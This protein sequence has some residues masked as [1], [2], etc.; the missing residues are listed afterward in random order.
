MT[1]CHLH[2]SDHCLLHDAGARIVFGSRVFCHAAATI[3]NSL[4]AALTDNFNN[5]LLSGFKCSLKTYFTN[6]HSR[7]SH[8]R[9]PS[10]AICFLKLTYGASPAA[11]LFDRLIS[12]LVTVITV[13]AGE[14]N[15]TVHINITAAFWSSVHIALQNHS[16]ATVWA[17]YFCERI[18]RVW[19]NLPDSV[20][21]TTLASFTCITKTVDFSKYLRCS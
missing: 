20:D 8:E 19:N 14:C 5:V 1:S 12:R 2:S 15:F 3:W 21:F 16:T 7:P 11:W 4:P 13:R 10:H 9:C 6:F 17:K 18:V